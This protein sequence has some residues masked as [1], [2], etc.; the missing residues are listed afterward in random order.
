MLSAV[1][2]PPRPLLFVPWTMAVEP[3]HGDFLG[4]AGAFKNITRTVHGAGLTSRLA[5]RSVKAG[6]LMAVPAQGWSITAYLI[7]KWDLIGERK[8][9]EE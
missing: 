1:S 8:K 4:I 3:K 7:P 5:P 6:E 2:P 9:K